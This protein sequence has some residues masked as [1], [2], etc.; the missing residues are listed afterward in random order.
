MRLQE[1]HAEL[2][3]TQK[4]ERSECRVESEGAARWKAEKKSCRRFFQ[5]MGG[6]KKKKTREQGKGKQEGK[7]V[8]ERKAHVA[9]I[10]TVW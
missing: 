3:V 2:R 5:S 4:W 7:E 10:L 8:L 9:S 6:W 1:R